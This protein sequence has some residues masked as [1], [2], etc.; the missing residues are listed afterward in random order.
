MAAYSASFEG[1]MSKFLI[2]VPRDQGEV[3]SRLQPLDELIVKPT[4]CA[5]SVQVQVPEWP[6]GDFSNFS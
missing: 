5:P 3:R 4:C 1:M 6:F 2:A